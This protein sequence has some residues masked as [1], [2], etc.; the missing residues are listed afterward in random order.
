MNIVLRAA[1]WWVSTVTRAFTEHT[2]GAAVICIV[3]IGLFIVLQKEYRPFGF[4]VNAGIVVLGWLLAITGLPFAMSGGANFVAT[5][6][7]SAPLVS[8][9]AAYLYGI[10]ERHP[11]MVLAIVGVGTTAYFLRQSWPFRLAWWP[12]RAVLTVLA[13]VLLVHVSAPIADLIEPV[14]SAPAAPKA[15]APLV[16]A[17]EAAAAAIKAGDL[18]YLS[19]AACSEEVAGASSGDAAKAGLKRLGVSCEDALGSEGVARVHAHREYATEYNRLM[20]QHNS[21]LEAKAAESKV[22]ETKPEA[23]P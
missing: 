2:L 10:Y 14:A 15:S 21:A 1:D 8:R 6:D 9:F 16:P 13:V 12:V 20:H 19:I 22:A 5:L 17:K 23:K 7:Q 11:Y 18:R 3:A 4:F